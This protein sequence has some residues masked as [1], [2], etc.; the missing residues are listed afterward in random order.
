[1]INIRPLDKFQERS[2]QMKFQI[3]IRAASFARESNMDDLDSSTCDS[4]CHKLNYKLEKHR[5]ANRHN[6]FRGRL[7][8]PI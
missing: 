3:V 7:K 1:M 8:D 6:L 2:N 4:E 5:E